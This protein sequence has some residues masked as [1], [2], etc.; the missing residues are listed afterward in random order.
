[1]HEYESD[2]KLNMD[3]EGGFAEMLQRRRELMGEGAAENSS[4]SDPRYR[5]RPASDPAFAEANII[6]PF[7]DRHIKTGNWT[8]QAD[9]SFLIVINGKNAVI[10]MEDGE[11]LVSRWDGQS[12]YADSLWSLESFLL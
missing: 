7:I 1:M 11:V 2:D 12:I 6:Y 3:S 4:Y 8:R 10:S 5:G 9:G